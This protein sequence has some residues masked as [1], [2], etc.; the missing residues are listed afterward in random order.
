MRP[1][2]DEVIDR[3]ISFYLNNII[4]MA[5]KDFDVIGAGML[6]ILFRGY[7]TTEARDLY[8][9]NHEIREALR[10]AGE[11]LREAKLEGIIATKLENTL[12][13]EQFSHG[14]FPTLEELREENKMLNEL[15]EEVLVGIYSLEN[16]PAII[17]DI[18]ADLRAVMKK[19]VEREYTAAYPV[20]E[21]A[22]KA[23]LFG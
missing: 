6:L 20:L 23:G 9:S 18:H 8:E 14:T 4:P 19:Q 16:P 22:L 15:L 13:E 1:N 17:V 2:S 5:S 11:G 10:N 7:Y 3:I 12:S 21:E